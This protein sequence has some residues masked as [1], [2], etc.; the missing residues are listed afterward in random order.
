MVQSVDV[1]GCGFIVHLCEFDPFNEVPK[2]AFFALGDDLGQVAPHGVILAFGE[3]QVV[4]SHRHVL[5]SVD[6]LRGVEVVELLHFGPDLLFR[7]RAGNP[8]L[9]VFHVVF[10][11]FYLAWLQDL[12]QIDLLSAR[13]LVVPL[14]TH[15]YSQ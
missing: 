2:C 12:L 7:I 6:D 13:F 14:E 10:K 1:P 8:G 9:E 4:G 3:L 15:I 5:L 11:H